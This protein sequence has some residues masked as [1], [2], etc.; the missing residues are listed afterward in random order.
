MTNKDKVNFFIKYK[1]EELNKEGKLKSQDDSAKILNAQLLVDQ[2]PNK[3]KNNEVYLSAVETCID[4]A[5]ELAKND[6]KKYHLANLGFCIYD[7]IKKVG[8][9]DKFLKALGIK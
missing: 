6:V 7:D 9:E 4:S 5:I 2:L 3:T 1:Q 8:L